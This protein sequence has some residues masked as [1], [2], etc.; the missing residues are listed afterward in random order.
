M[1]ASLIRPTHQPAPAGWYHCAEHSDRP[2]PL[3][4]FRGYDSFER[5]I[6]SQLNR[7]SLKR[8]A[9]LVQRTIVLAPM[10]RC[11]YAV[12]SLSVINHA[13]RPHLR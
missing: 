6:S 5:V 4:S 11:R 2:M 8:R 3:K 7:W 10:R 13:E 9:G 1:V 12:A